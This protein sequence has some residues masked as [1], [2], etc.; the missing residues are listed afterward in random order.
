VYSWLRDERNGNWLLVLDNVD[1]AS[2]LLRTPDVN[3][4]SGSNKFPLRNRMA[5]LPPCAQGSILITSRSRATTARLTD[6]CDIITV[7]PMEEAAALALLG[8]KLGQSG[9][10]ED[11]RKLATALDHMPLALAQAGAYIKQ[12]GLR[13]SVARYLAKLEK[14]E[15]SQASLLESA[16]KE[17]RRDEEAQDS[18]ILTWQISFD[19]IRATRPSAADLLSLMSMYN[20]QG[21]PEYLLRVGGGDTR[22]GTTLASDPDSVERDSDASSSASEDEDSEEDDFGDD[23]LTLESFHFISTMFSNRSFEMHRLV[24]LSARVWLRSNGTYQGRARKSI[25]RLNEA[26]PNGEH[27]NWERCRELYPHVTS[28]L[29]LQLD[30]KE[31][32][33]PRASVQHKAAWFDWRRGLWSEAE[34]LVSKSYRTRTTVLGSED[35]KTLSALHLHASVLSRLGKYEAAEEMNRRALEGSEKVLGKEHPDTLTSVS[36]MA[37]LLGRQGKY[38]A[39]EEMNRRALEGKEKVLGKEHP[40]TLTSVSNLALLLS[41]QG[42]YEAAE[43]MNR[44]ALEGKEKVLGKEHPS[45]LMSVGNLAS[46]LGSQG[47]YEAAEEMNRRALEGKEKVLGKEHP[48]TLISV[49]CLADLLERVSRE[50]DA[51]LLYERAI[52]GLSTSLGTRHPHTLQCH[53]SLKRLQG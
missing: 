5:Y 48:D 36:D 3:D 29:S 51:V 53:R 50:A 35:E 38:V 28:T 23:I 7:S 2:F 8:K 4:E 17:L 30:D 31:I 42:K 40:S 18:I 32:S 44:R 1:D 24:Q 9:A 37:F 34:A 6:D 21:I 10:T 22:P 45:T 12:R 43:E 41:R 25:E 20:Y 26:L 19:Y 27:E 33:L 14:S 49:W 16:S 39:A 15:K 52:A 13:Y 11:M 47:K 46:V